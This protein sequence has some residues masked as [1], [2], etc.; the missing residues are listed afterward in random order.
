MQTWQFPFLVE[1]MLAIGA[2]GGV[3]APRTA[4]SLLRA[5][6]ELLSRFL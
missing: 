3:R 2:A 5:V 6:G 4:R 1:N